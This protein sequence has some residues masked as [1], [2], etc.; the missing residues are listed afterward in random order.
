V[1]A[2]RDSNAI[3]LF[4]GCAIIQATESQRQLTRRLL[5]RNAF[6]DWVGRRR[7]AVALWLTA[8]L[9]AIVMAGLLAGGLLSM[10][11]FLVAMIFPLLLLLFQLL[12]D[13][14]GRIRSAGRT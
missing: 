1:F 2:T 3:L 4:S 9:A 10:S 6:F 5:L 12:W 13:R 14:R 7:I 8:I 11:E